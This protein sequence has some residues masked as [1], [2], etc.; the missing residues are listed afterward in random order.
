MTKPKVG[1]RIKLI[2]TDDQCTRL[3][4]GDMGTISDL[5]RLPQSLGN[6]LQIWI[7]WDN[8]SHLALLDGQDKYLI[9]D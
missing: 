2:S 1:K 3:K 7:R 4:T 5:T 8:G 9:I 6:T